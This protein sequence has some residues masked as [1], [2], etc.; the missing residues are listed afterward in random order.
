MPWFQTRIGSL[1]LRLGGVALLALAYAAAH[2]LRA[3]AIAGPIMGDPLGWLL[4][5]VSFLLGSIGA[6]SLAMGRHLFD[7]IEVSRRWSRCQR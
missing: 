2:G 6:A 5:A 1:T 3:R 4:A 7:R